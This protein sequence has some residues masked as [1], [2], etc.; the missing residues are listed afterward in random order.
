[1]LITIVCIVVI[2]G[3]SYAGKAPDYSKISGLTFA[4]MTPEDRKATRASWS[5]KDVLTSILLLAAII[6]AYLYFTG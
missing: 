4:T 6:G 5:N 3:V 1:L 2:I